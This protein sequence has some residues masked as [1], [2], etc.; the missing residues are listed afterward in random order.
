MSSKYEEELKKVEDNKNASEDELL[1][2]KIKAEVSDALLRSYVRLVEL[3]YLPYTDDNE[4]DALKIVAL[5]LANEDENLR[6][7]FNIISE[8]F[9][10]KVLTS[11]KTEPAILDSISRIMSILYDTNQFLLPSPQFNIYTMGD[12]KISVN[13]TKQVENVTEPEVVEQK[14]ESVPV[15][16]L[17]NK[18]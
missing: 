15:S 12:D 16:E 7:P 17:I 1:I 4:K 5:S 11:I 9:D 18:D 13:N 6:K 3:I 10:D 14:P 8:D 2:A